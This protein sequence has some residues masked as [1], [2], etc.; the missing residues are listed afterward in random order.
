MVTNLRKEHPKLD[1]VIVEDGLYSRQPFIDAVKQ[2]R[3]SYILLKTK[4]IISSTTTV[5]GV[6]ACRRTSLCSTCWRFLCLRS[7][8]SP[9]GS[10]CKVGSRP[11]HAKNIFPCCAIHSE[12][13]CSGTGSTFSISSTP[14]RTSMHL[15]F[16]VPNHYR[17]YHPE[18]PVG[19]PVFC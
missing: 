4:A 17:P 13:Y 9:I 3:M 18:I 19:A 15:R 11:V 5:A 14:L 12:F 6:R 16:S 7:L 10:I 2:S 1:M 8:S